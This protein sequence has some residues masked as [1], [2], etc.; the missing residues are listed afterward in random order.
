MLRQDDGNN[1]RIHLSGIKRKKKLF[2]PHNTK[3][4]FTQTR[5]R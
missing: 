4:K 3:V 2:S 1:V 5:L